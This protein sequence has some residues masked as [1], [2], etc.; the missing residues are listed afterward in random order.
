MK[1]YIAGP[2]TGAPDYKDTFNQAELFLQNKGH[3]VMNPSIL[4]EG[5]EHEEY[6]KICYAMV[7]V[8]DAV[9]MLPNWERSKGAQ[10]EF[11]YAQEE[12][13]LVITEF[14]K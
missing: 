9:Y 11:L 8:C 10:L 13:K 3:T 2:I 12:G 1:I 6:M 4:P 5:F 14:T 7:D